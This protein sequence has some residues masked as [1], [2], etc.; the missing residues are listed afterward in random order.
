MYD[1]YNDSNDEE[2]HEP[3]HIIINQNNCK[4]IL[5]KYKSIEEFCNDV[6]S[7]DEFISY[8]FPDDIPDEWSLKDREKSHGCGVNQKS[9]TPNLFRYFNRWV[10]LKNDCKLWNKE[11]IVS[12]SIQIVKD[13]LHSY[14]IEDELYYKYDDKVK[15]LNNEKE[16]WNLNSLKII[17]SALD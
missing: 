12:Q 10:D 13:T 5:E 14:Y 3:N 6:D 2:L 9:D 15:E 8:Y 17:L 1:D 4:T 16:R 7:Y 11:Q